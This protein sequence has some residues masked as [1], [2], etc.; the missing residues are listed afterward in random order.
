MNQ[1][2]NSLNSVRTCIPSKKFIENGRWAGFIFLII[3]YLL[4]LASAI[5]LVRGRK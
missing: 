4:V 3:S 5:W 2:N 1:E